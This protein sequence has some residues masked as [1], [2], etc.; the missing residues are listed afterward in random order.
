MSMLMRILAGI[1]LCGGL[2]GAGTAAESASQGIDCAQASGGYE[3]DMCDSDRLDDADNELNAVYAQARS[4]LKAQAADGSCSRCVSAEQQLVK[5]Q[6]IWITLRD[7][8]CE[9]V[10]AFNAD[11][12]SRNPAKMQCLITQTRDR[13]RQLRAFYELI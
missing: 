4:E 12:T 6:R 5:A 8:D 10:Y 2:C 7:A 13:T 11:G 3:R 9:A 1:M